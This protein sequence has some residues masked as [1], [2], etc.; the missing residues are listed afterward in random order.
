[1]IHPRNQPA[2]PNTPAAEMS[3]LLPGANPFM[4]ERGADSPSPMAEENTTPSTRLPS[5]TPSFSPWEWINGVPPGLSPEEKRRHIEM[6]DAQKALYP[7][8]TSPPPKTARAAEQKREGS[9]AVLIR[10]RRRGV[11]T[12]VGECG[13]VVGGSSGSREREGLAS[14]GV[15][16]DAALGEEQGSEVYKRSP[17]NEEARLDIMRPAVS[18][19]SD[20]DVDTYDKMHGSRMAGQDTFLTEPKEENPHSSRATD[21]AIR[22]KPLS[23]SIERSITTSDDGRSLRDEIHRQD[24]MVSAV[25]SEAMFNPATIENFAKRGHCGKSR[26][27]NTPRS[28]QTRNESC[29]KDRPLGYVYGL[30]N[31]TPEPRYEAEDHSRTDTLTSAVSS[32]AMFNRD[33]YEDRETGSRRNYRQHESSQTGRR[34]NESSPQDRSEDFIYGMIRPPPADPAENPNRH[35]SIA[36]EV[37][38]GEMINRTKRQDEGRVERQ[39]SQAKD[40]QRETKARV[41][42]NQG[43]NIHQARQQVKDDF[44]QPEQ[45]PP[46]RQ[47]D[48]FYGVSKDDRVGSI[49]QDNFTNVNSAVPRLVTPDSDTDTQSKKGQ[50]QNSP[51][52]SRFAYKHP[53]GTSTTRILS[54]TTTTQ[55]SKSKGKSSEQRKEEDSL[56]VALEKLG[57]AV[58]GRDEPL[59]RPGSWLANPYFQPPPVWNKPVDVEAVLGFRTPH[60]ID[61]ETAAEEPTIAKAVVLEAP[62]VDYGPCASSERIIPSLE[63]HPLDLCDCYSERSSNY[64]YTPSTPLKRVVRSHRDRSSS[65]SRRHYRKSVHQPME[66]IEED[67]SEDEKTVYIG[68]EV[69]PTEISPS[70]LPPSIVLHTPDKSTADEPMFSPRHSLNTTRLLRPIPSQ[71]RPIPHRQFR[72]Q[73]EDILSTPEKKSFWNSGIFCFQ[74]N[75]LHS[76]LDYFRQIGRDFPPGSDRIP[77]SALLFANTGLIHAHLGDYKVA[78]KF[79]AKACFNEPRTSLFWFLLGCMVWELGSWGHAKLYFD[80]GWYTFPDGVVEVDYAGRGLDFLLEKRAVWRNGHVALYGMRRA[81]EGIVIPEDY[82]NIGVDRMPGGKMFLS[83]SGQS[84]TELQRQ[85]R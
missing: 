51:Q 46:R 78:S 19:V 59:T 58:R 67:G 30:R 54:P 20:F 22:S 85:T 40:R 4:R 76:S 65:S 71:H 75:D 52:Q 41:R 83:G 82:R 26:P 80:A 70:L 73:G 36:S 43:I 45:S 74:E 50:A 11:V 68:L 5:L 42:S 32:L 21:A 6:L 28:C 24:S 23:S 12:Q 79:F 27:P 39:L 63:E 1:M 16:D 62:V 49:L 7:P 81:A 25:A 61:E 29:A 72:P 84:L 47:I 64:E 33:T 57:K 2:G 9:A 18:F 34:R 66:E 14:V 38:F 69:D 35:Y 55:R 15:R 56:S 8:L 13:D 60:R 17:R 3:R 77:N 37:F 10:R 31:A 48:S 44:P 53:Y